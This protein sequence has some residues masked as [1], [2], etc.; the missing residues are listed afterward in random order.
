LNDAMDETNVVAFRV[1]NSA[2]LSEAFRI[3]DANG[4]YD[5]Y[6]YPISS[7]L[8]ETERFHYYYD[9]EMKAIFNVNGVKMAYL[10][11]CVD[12]SM[13]NGFESGIL[14]IK[15]TLGGVKGSAGF[16]VRQLGNQQFVKDAL[17]YGDIIAPQLATRGNVSS[18]SVGIFKD[19]VVPYS[20]AV[21][22]LSTE[23]YITVT[24]VVPGG[25]RL[26]NN[27]VC[28]KE[29]TFNLKLLGDYK[30]NYSLADGNENENL[31]SYNI[32]SVDDEA[33]NLTVNGKYNAEYAAGSTVTLL[34]TTVSDKVATENEITKCVIV[35]NPSYF[36]VR[37]NEGD[38]YKFADRG[39]YRIR[40]VV[41]DKSGNYSFVDY[42]IVVY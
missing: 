5:F 22:V 25:E 9:N 8:S 41:Y 30:L 38:T 20:Y 13:F 32:A 12:G 39:I 28:D 37:V 34:N 33:P 24:F 35:T 1:Y 14:N 15:V 11:Y 10:R 29:Y 42:N 4:T 6:K 17:K 40:H 18:G 23:T 3:Q 27:A 36:S 31:I 26:L 21:D 16:V 2:V 19:F 7:S